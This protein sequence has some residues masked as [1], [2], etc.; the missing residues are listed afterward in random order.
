MKKSMFNWK[1][2]AIKYLLL[3]VMLLTLFASPVFAIPPRGSSAGTNEN[4]YESY[5]YWV[6]GAAKGPGMTYTK[7]VYVP[8][9]AITV[10][11]L[12]LPELFEEITDI[13]TDEQGRLF[14][15]DGVAGKVHITDSSYKLIKT[16]P[17]LVYTGE[18]VSM[19]D[20]S[21][22]EI[23]LKAG[24]I[25][26]YKDALGIFVK[27]DVIYIADTKNH[28]VLVSDMDGKVS[29]CLGKPVSHLIDEDFDYKPQKVAVDSK[30]YTYVSCDGSYYGAL[31]YSPEME[32]LGFYGANT[33]PA[34]VLDVLSNLMDRLFSN[35][36]KK[37]QQALSLPYQFVDMV[38]GPEDFIYTATSRIK[39]GTTQTGQISIMN[40]GGADIS[41][42]DAYNF[43]DTVTGEYLN[44]PVTPSVVGV[45]VDDDGFFFIVDSGFGRIFMYDEECN[46]ISAFG[47]ALGEH[48]QQGTNRY[49]RAIAVNG[50]DVLVADSQ[51]NVVNRYVITD[52]GMLV[53]SAQMKT[54]E[55]DFDRAIEE[56]E[57][58]IG[59]DQNN[60]LAYA[61]LAKAYYTLGDNEKAAHYAELALDRE[62]YANAFVKLRQDF[63]EENFT[64]IFIVAVLLIAGLIV[65]SVIKKK[66][67]WKFVKNEKLQVLLGSVAHPVDS[68][69]LVK[70]KKQ[71]SLR[72]AFMVLAIFYILSAVSDTATGFAYNYFD[73]S[74]YNSF[75]LLLST[76][77]LV[78]LWVCANWMVCVLLG[79]IGRLK[80]I[81]IVTCYC[82]IP[83][84]FS[85]TIS[86]VL[87]HVLVPEE[88]V[89]V[90]LLQSA[91][92]LY[93]AFMLIVGIMRIHD[94]EFGRFLGTTILTVV[95][96]VIIVF[97]I[98]LVFLL[99]QQVWSWVATL[100]IEIKYR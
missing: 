99:A 98:F 86:L 30:D 54:L 1:K 28:R 60:Q 91:C 61:G 11:S 56:W 97:L 80:E 36:V 35:D 85:S 52:Y 55:D 37:A 68:F 9:K 31:V 81:F 63:L 89:F 22:T 43:A 71:G 62:T 78:I 15:L 48:V 83:L 27:N 75:Y 51:K 33:V 19:K 49:A 58:V 14:I 20:A 10:D 34:T 18:P 5:N 100:F 45:D 46:L 26:E 7:P 23:T 64:W 2:L 88:F 39:E 96:M 24:D 6:D 50:T 93:A 84:I 38:V 53:R 44:A 77:G 32:F 67:G 42:K 12:G 95:A 40:P 74:T 29:Y 17:D 41:G 92:V 13:C 57:L 72:L 59:Q 65:F 21:E 3:P 76:V 87:T 90:S 16:L 47:G 8:A 25:I 79:G 94:F 73:A 4:V 66:K 82:L 69:R 70:E